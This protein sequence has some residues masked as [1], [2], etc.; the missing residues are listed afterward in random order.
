[1]WTYVGY[2]AGA[3]FLLWLW[4]GRGPSLITV[5]KE[6]EAQQDIKP[7]MTAV[8][9]LSGKRRS[10]FMQQTIEILWRKWE[11]ELAANVIEQFAKLHPEEKISQY[12]IRQVL[13]FEPKAAKKAFTSSFLDNHYQ[14]DV[15][16]MCGVASS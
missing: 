3:L 9:K 4:R 2:G 11:R 7:I 5:V 1:M 8:E 6:A 12:W 15:A 13:E 14:A 16:A 10:Y